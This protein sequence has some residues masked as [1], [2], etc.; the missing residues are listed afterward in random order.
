MAFIFLFLS[1]DETALLHERIGK[2]VKELINT[3]GFFHYAWVIP[4]GVALIVILIGYLNFLKKLPRNIMI[5]F[6]VSGAIYISGALGF[7]MAG[8]R[9]HE[10]YGDDTLLYSLLYTCEE[11]L[12]MLGIL[13]FIYAL[14]MYIKSQFKSLTITV[15]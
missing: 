3:S 9:H 7:E 1:I 6:M 10:L 11:F 5:L 15:N 12:E 2:S 13:I 4:Y 14:L 8:G